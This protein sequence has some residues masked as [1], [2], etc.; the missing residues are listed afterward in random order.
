MKVLPLEI[1]N[2]NNKINIIYSIN[3]LINTR[4][5]NLKIRSFDF[6]NQSTKINGRIYSTS[7]LPF[8][9]PIKSS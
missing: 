1:L 6:S 2:F 4:E 9:I 3:L 5:E 7:F 8:P